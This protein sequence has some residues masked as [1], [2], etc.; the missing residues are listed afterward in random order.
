MNN[1]PKKSKVCSP[2]MCFMTEK[3]NYICCGISSKPSRFKCD[4]IWLCLKGKVASTA[5]EM[6][7]KEALTIITALSTGVNTL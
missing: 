2:T 6:T 3:K 1:C 4:T 5:L 7:P